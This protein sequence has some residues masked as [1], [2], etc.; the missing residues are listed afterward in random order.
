VL[1]TLRGEALGDLGKRWFVLHACKLLVGA[2][3]FALLS[4]SGALA[5]PKPF[6]FDADLAGGSS[7]VCADVHQN[8]RAPLGVTILA[9]HG[10]TETAKA[11]EP[12]AQAIFADPLL[13]FTVK[14]VVALDLPGRGGS[15]APIGLPNARF[16]ELTLHDNVSVVIQTIEALRGAGLGARVIMGHSM[17][18][19]A[20]Q[21]VQEALLTSGSSLAALGVQRAILIAAVPALSA[22]WTQPPGAELGDF[23]VDDPALGQYLDLPPW[24]VQLSGG[25]TTTG[26]VLAATTPSVEAIAPTVGWEPIVTTLQLVGQVPGLPRLDAREGAFALRRG[27]LLSV[28]GFSEDVLTPAAD[29][30]DLYEYLIGRPGFRYFLVEGPDAVH[31]TFIA[32]PESMMSAVRGS[33]I[34]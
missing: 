33:L 31:N 4:Q 18:G 25:Y 16:G 17:G 23:V 1:S 28:I 29:Q 20:I 10:F 26:G 2:L 11:F 32:D 15:E 14:R 6:C 3:A 12:L 7:E 34:P 13:R 8:P 9:I 22:T 5:Q 27:T 21:G 24:L 30:D 19:L